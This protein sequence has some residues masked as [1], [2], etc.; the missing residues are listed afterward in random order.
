M[1]QG[2]LVLLSDELKLFLQVHCN[3]NCIYLS[4][5][6]CWFL[7][8]NYCIL[9]KLQAPATT[10]PRALERYIPN[11]DLVSLLRIRPTTCINQINIQHLLRKHYTRINNKNISY[12]L[13]QLNL[14][15]QIKSLTTSNFRTRKGTNFICGFYTDKKRFPNNFV[16]IDDF[17]IRSKRGKRTM[18]VLHEWQKCLL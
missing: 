11:S 13:N 16:V 2:K 6:R 15:Q 12:Y 5:D 7:I 1:K 8:K 18:C 4:K 9:N 10:P 17:T 14:I 3:E